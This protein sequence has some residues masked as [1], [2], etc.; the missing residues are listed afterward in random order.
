MKQRLNFAMALS[1]FALTFSACEKDDHDDHDHENELITTVEL[2]FTETGTSNT[3]VFE[4]NDPDG[5]GG[6]APTIDNIELDAN[7]Q[8]DL[9]LAFLD[10]SK[11]PVEDITEEIEEEGDVH[12]IYFVPSASLNF[13]VGQ[14]DTDENGRPLGLNSSVS[15]GAAST[16]TLQVVLRHYGNGGKE[17]SDPVNSSKSSSDV[18]VVFNVAI[19]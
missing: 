19:Q 17:A 7:T 13:T 2:R 16:G 15:T 3:V 14:Q 18:D 12:R 5:P 8:Y 11:N 4:F 1:I 6:A 10:R 9:E